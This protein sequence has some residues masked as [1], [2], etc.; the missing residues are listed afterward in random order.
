MVELNKVIEAIAASGA[1]SD[2]SKFDP[3]KTFKENKIDSLD[4]LSLF[5]A[6]EEHLGIKFTDDEVNQINSAAQMV[7]TINTR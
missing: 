1:V 7:E 4:V 2:M 6:V 5:L 3:T